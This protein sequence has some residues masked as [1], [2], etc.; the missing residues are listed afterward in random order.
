MGKSACAEMLRA[1]AIPVV[2][3]DDLARQVV[4]PGQPALAEIQHLFG[5]NLVGPDGRLHRDELARRVFVDASARQQLERILHPRIRELWHAQMRTWRDE[6]RRMA[7][8]VIPLLFET[9][10]EEEL[11]ATICIACSAATQRQRLL[12]RGWSSEQIQQRLQAQWPTAKKM[13]HSNY[14][15][16][17][18]GGLDLHAAQLDRILGD[19]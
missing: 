14:V 16:W 19:Q 6:G 4:E 9:G 3:T 8:V 1:R 10:A 18:E 13:D 5:A 15:I 11:D 2:D 7:V 17:T 12:A